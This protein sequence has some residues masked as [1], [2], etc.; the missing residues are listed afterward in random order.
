MHLQNS[1]YC[2]C[3]CTKE[4]CYTDMEYGV[5]KV[6][7]HLNCF[8]LCK[9]RHLPVAFLCTLCCA[10]IFSSMWAA[11]RAFLK[12]GGACHSRWGRA[13]HQYRYGCYRFF[14]K[15]NQQIKVIKKNT[16]YK[17]MYMW[18]RSAWLI[19]ARNPEAALSS[20]YFISWC[21]IRIKTFDSWVGIRW[22]KGSLNW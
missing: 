16:R 11:I 3:T 22:W 1:W 14:D 13:T 19:N 17:F 18:I 6:M 21:W 10:V 12:P 20:I 5:G 15:E 4:A 8:L 9:N 7:V 2:T